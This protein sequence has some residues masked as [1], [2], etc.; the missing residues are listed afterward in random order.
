MSE[1]TNNNYDVSHLEKHR[2][3]S[4][5]N[6]EVPACEIINCAFLYEAG[7]YTTMQPDYTSSSHWPALSQNWLYPPISS[8]P[9]FTMP[10]GLHPDSMKNT[11]RF[12][13]QML[14]DPPGDKPALLTPHLNPCGLSPS[15][16]PSSYPLP[17]RG[18]SYYPARNPLRRDVLL[19]DP[20]RLTERGEMNPCFNQML[21]RNMEQS[22]ESKHN[23]FIFLFERN[24]Y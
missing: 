19:T 16:P 12:S 9:Y 13:E 8:S 2:Y 17:T 3:A 14:R 24:V 5:F 4:S 6:S 1:N 21:E 15:Y 22:S 11:S 7:H 20:Y 18:N 10:P 23:C